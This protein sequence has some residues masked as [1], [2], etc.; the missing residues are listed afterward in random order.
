M[1]LQ[2]L[3]ERL[4]LEIHRAEQVL[5]S[6]ETPFKMDDV[7]KFNRAIAQDTLK[8]ILQILK[9]RPDAT[10]AA[11]EHDNVGRLDKRSCPKL[12]PCPV[13]IVNMDTFECAEALIT[14]ETDEKP[15]VVLN[16]ANAHRLGG[17][18]LRRATP[19]EQLCYRSTLPAC[20]AKHTYPIP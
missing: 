20:L 9:R 6:F 5:S 13:Q 17:A 12:T 7:W 14:S 1:L 10:P 19:Q 2:V 16:M 3:E 8:C 18:W 4:C 11:K 15:V